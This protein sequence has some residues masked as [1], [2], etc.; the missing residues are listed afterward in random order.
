MEFAPGRA[1]SCAS[2]IGRIGCCG[3][4]P[5]LQESQLAV[6]SCRRSLWHH[7]REQQ[8]SR[9]STRALISTA[10]TPYQRNADENASKS[11]A[12]LYTHRPGELAQLCSGAG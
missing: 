11:V 2:W 9:S 1:D 5:A 3:G 8:I 12:A 6:L 10:L 7:D 4:F